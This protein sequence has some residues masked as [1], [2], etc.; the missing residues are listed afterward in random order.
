MR[1]RLQRALI[2]RCRMHGSMK[3]PF[4][5][6]YARLP[7]RFF[8]R[9]S[10]AVVPGAKLIRLNEGLAA[11]LGLDRAWLRTPEGVGMLSGNCVPDGAEPIA[12]AY[13]GN[14]FG[15]WVPQLGDGRA[16][17]LGE[18][19]D[20]GGTRRDIQLKGSGR[21]PFSRGGDGKAALGPVLREYLVSEAMFALGM[22]TTRALAAVSTGE[23]VQRDTLL[24]GAIFTRI[25]ASHIRVGTFQFF[26]ARNDIDGLRLLADHAIARHYPNAAVEGNPYLAFLRSVIAAQADL[27]ARWMPLGFIHGVMNTDNVAISGETIDFGPCAFMDAFH[28]QCVFSA[29]D[30]NGRYAWANQPAICEWNL[31]RLAETLLPLLDNSIEAAT[32]LAEA[33]LDE[34]GARFQQRYLAGFRAKL[35]LPDDAGADSGAAFI[36]ATLGTLAEQHVDFTLFF[37][38]LTR[39]AEGEN[40]DALSALFAS[41]ESG[42]TWLATWRAVA[43]PAEQLAKMRASNPVI[44]P[45]NHRVEEAIQHAYQGDFAPFHRLAD[46]LSEPYAERAETSDL[47]RAPQPHEVVRQ[48]FCGT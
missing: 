31:T 33:A 48:T 40:P 26:A 17:L 27:V 14:Q 20:A 45:R 47:E 34:F 23:L 38:H 36:K 10:P 43:K 21:T 44:I 1:E 6:T 12:Q 5:N 46:A 30:R 35:G 15:G 7:E 11:Q 8:A 3:I 13:A 41:R 9:Q 19:V 16:I 42:E 25:A 18:V 22:P 24:P 2:F 4:D 28:P 37:R 32:E 39:I 29:I